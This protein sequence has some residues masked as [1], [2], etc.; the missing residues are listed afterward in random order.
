MNVH[1]RKVVVI[2]RDSKKVYNM[3]EKLRRGLF[4]QIDDWFKLPIERKSR[5]DTVLLSIGELVSSIKKECKEFDRPVSKI[6]SFPRSFL[7][8]DG[9]F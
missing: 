3:Y 8:T 9:M 2:F 1:Q 6:E 4:D 5:R 7:I